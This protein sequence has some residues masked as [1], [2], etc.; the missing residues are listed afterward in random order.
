MGGARQ[1]IERRLNMILRESEP[2]RLPIRALFGVVLL[3]LIAL[4]GFTDG[5]DSNATR[6]PDEKPAPA[7][8]QAV[9]RDVFVA[10][11]DS[12]KPAVDEREQRLQKLEASLEALLKEVRQMRGATKQ[13]ADSTPKAHWR[14]EANPYQIQPGAVHKYE[15]QRSTASAAQGQAK[16]DQ[17]IHLCRI[18]YA[19]PKEK[20]EALAAVLKDV[21]LPVL[22]TAVKA[23]AIVV[24]TTPE[25]QRI[26]GEFVG[27][28]QGKTPA[29]TGSSSS[30]SAPSNYAPAKK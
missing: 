20:A 16:P 23:D 18:T 1:E 14:I 11:S 5:Q 25:G 27:L 10:P 9:L 12:T 19:L 3:G 24:T 6:P 13:P 21:K 17:P 26:I 29:A 4:P 8:D 2:T 15:Y 7:V 22:E 28:L 30:Y